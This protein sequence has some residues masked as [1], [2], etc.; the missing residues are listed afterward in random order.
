MIFDEIDRLIKDFVPKNGRGPE[1]L[2][3][4]KKH[5]QEIFNSPDIMSFIDFDEWRFP[6]RIKGLLMD[7]VNV[8]EVSVR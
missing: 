7:V 5:R 2:V 8:S 6:K 3:L 1:V 4:N